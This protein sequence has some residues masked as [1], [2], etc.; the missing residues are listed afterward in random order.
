M[1]LDRLHE[2]V[3]RVLLLTPTII[4]DSTSPDACPN[5]D[6]VGHLNLVLEIETEFG[7]RFSVEEI[8]ELSTVGRIREALQRMGALGTPPVDGHQSS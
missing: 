7:V 4:D 6:S 8:P 1:S 3:G 2:I 5:W